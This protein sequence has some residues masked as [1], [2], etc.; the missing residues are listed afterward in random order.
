MSRHDC[1]KGAPALLPALPGPPFC[2]IVPVQ[3]MVHALERMSPKDIRN[4][5]PAHHH[6]VQDMP[7]I[8]SGPHPPLLLSSSIAFPHDTI[9]VF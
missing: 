7:V 6:T 3:N 1:E 4:F 8:L 5:F 2:T 9:V